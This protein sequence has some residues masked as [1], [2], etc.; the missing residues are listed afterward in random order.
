MMDDDNSKLPEADGPREEEEKNGSTDVEGDPSRMIAHD[1]NG[2][3]NLA[4]DPENENENEKHDGDGNGSEEGMA[5]IEEL[6][7]VDGREWQSKSSSPNVPR[8]ARLVREARHGTSEFFEYMRQG[9][10]ESQAAPAAA[11]LQVLL[12]QPPAS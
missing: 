10:G 3:G 1:R 12:C 8:R 9:Y 7:V 4:G 5:A 6:H 2:S 11:S